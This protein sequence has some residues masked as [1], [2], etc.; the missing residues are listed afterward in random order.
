MP[1]IYELYGTAGQKFLGLFKD[2]IYRSLD[3]LPVCR[4]NFGDCQ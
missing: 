1:S 4:K 3:E 2:K